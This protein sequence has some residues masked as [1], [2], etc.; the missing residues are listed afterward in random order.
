MTRATRDTIAG[1]GVMAA[2]LVHYYDVLL[3]PAN[4]TRPLID[5][6]QRISTGTDLA[7]DQYRLLIPKLVTFVARQTSVALDA[8]IIATDAAC[9]LSG[10]LLLASALRRSGMESQILT[11][12]LYV[13]GFAVCVLVLPRPETLP[14]FLGAT[15]I[16]N[17]YIHTGRRAATLGAA[18]AVLLAGCRPETVVAAAIPFILKWHGK[19]LRIRLAAGSVLVVLG[20]LGALIPPML[21]PNTPYLTSPVQIP[22]N[23][24]PRSYLVPIALLSPVL[25]SLTRSAL[26]R[27]APLLAW[28][29]A[30]LAMIFVVGRIDEAR[31][32]FP[33]SG[34]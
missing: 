4:P 17:A 20:A 19:R 30:E 10:A 14:A 6:Y 9:L 2:F 27:C 11:A 7:P 13:S 29:C 21:Y 15:C 3:H 34:C 16:L 5:R 33:L 32:Y 1:I 28:V 23:L 26:F 24:D 12:L 8:A 18:G 31:I 22:H 25:V